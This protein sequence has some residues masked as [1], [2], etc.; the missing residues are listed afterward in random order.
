MKQITRD[1][2][3]ALQGMAPGIC[4]ADRNMLL[5][6]LRGGELFENFPSPHRDK[7]W[8]RVC[9]ASKRSLIPSLCTFFRDR[10]L[11]HDV[12]NGLRKILNVGRGKTIL[13]ALKEI[14]SDANQTEGR[15]KIQCSAA[16]FKTIVGN[17]DL[18]LDLGIRQLWLAA[19]R[20]YE[21]LPAE[22]QKPG[23]LALSRTKAD[24][25]TLHD[26][27]SLA[28]RLGFE[29]D[30]LDEI[31]RKSP[32]RSIAEHAL[33]TA[34][35]PGSYVFHDAESCIQK[36]QEA[37]AA[38]VP[39][40]EGKT[41]QGACDEVRQ[42]EEPPRRY[43]RPIARDNEYDKS[44]L[45]LPRMQEELNGDLGEMTSTFVRWSFYGAYFGAPPLPVLDMI[46]E[47]DLMTVDVEMASSVP[48]GSGQENGQVTLGS[49]DA[50]GNEDVIL[51]ITRQKLDLEQAKLH[52]T[53]QQMQEKTMELK[54]LTVEEVTQ[55]R[56]LAAMKQEIHEQEAR[57]TDLQQQHTQKEE[58]LSQL[59]AMADEEQLR[60]DNA[61][62]TAP[63]EYRDQA[64]A[65][66]AE[67][68]TTVR[69]SEGIIARD[70]EP[71]A[72]TQADST[73]LVPATS[74]SSGVLSAPRTHRRT[75]FDFSEFLAHDPN[76]EHLAAIT[77][78][79]A[80]E[81]RPTPK[82]RIDFV[83]MESPESFVITD[84]VE[85]DPGNVE[86]V[87]RVQRLATSYLRRHYYLFDKQHN[88][89]NPKDCLRKVVDDGSHT[90]VL[91]RISV[92]KDS[93]KYSRK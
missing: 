3:S 48:T 40:P 20:S 5:S 41:A 18:R 70:P 62:K 61:R 73:G 1:T 24:G 64:T 2:V 12:A 89:L 56:R 60:L 23:L 14:F 46:P 54:G 11:L 9:D 66:Q 59:K 15:C 29:S 55:Q 81:N 32:D 33:F 36:I 88:H 58:E 92:A 63:R 31:L 45:F 68:A 10:I 16:S 7:L 22:A 71:S 37:F 72:S 17:Y 82:I 13:D 50:M 80:D 4:S 53:S 69:S 47:E 25:T 85:V 28:S 8:S 84:V 91:E 6:K 77:E 74:M 87:E 51:A 42:L 65:T 52:E 30:K 26:L 78:E 86:D 49:E 57:L 39:A 79:A 35:K 19:F 38:A 83:E 44:R 21:G 76:K 27:A 75:R 43:G 67:F 93:N 90:I 34:R